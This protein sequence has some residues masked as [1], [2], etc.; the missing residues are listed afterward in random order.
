MTTQPPSQA[1][2]IQLAAFQQNEPVDEHEA[3]VISSPDESQEDTSHDALDFYIREEALFRQ[4]IQ[5]DVVHERQLM[6]RVALVILWVIA[7]ILIRQWLLLI[8]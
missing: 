2:I 8:I 1:K 3:P 5:L 7:L 6:Y 4:N